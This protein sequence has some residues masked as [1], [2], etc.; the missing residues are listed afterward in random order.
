MNIPG[1]YQIQKA[2]PRVVN[3][4]GVWIILRPFE[5]LQFKIAADFLH[6]LI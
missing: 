6:G 2:V 3:R 1:F 5:I 4:H